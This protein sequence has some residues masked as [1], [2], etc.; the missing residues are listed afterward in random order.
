MSTTMRKAGVI[1]RGEPLSRGRSAMGRPW[2]RGVAR[3][4]RWAA[5][6]PL[7]TVVTLTLVN[8][9]TLAALIAVLVASATQSTIGIAVM[10][11]FA[12]EV[13]VFLAIAVYIVIPEKGP[14]SGG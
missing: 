6:R 9:A 11:L 10:T 8:L 7:L 2:W 13:L 5:S 3:F 1:A 12:A 14:S 4:L